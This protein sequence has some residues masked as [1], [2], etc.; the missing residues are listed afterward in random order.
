[1]GSS[2]LRTEGRGEKERCAVDTPKTTVVTKGG[3]RV[4][5]EGRP[6][7]PGLV[8]RLF[9]D[10]WDD[11]RTLST[12]VSDPEADGPRHRRRPHSDVWGH[13]ATFRVESG[14][15]G[16]ALVRREE[17]LG[18]HNDSLSGTKSV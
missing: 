3:V 5:Y 15:V 11:R 1:M 7:G 16:V 17:S 12:V 18:G 2:V 13:V 9:F 10:P 14:V 4:G 6:K 8:Y